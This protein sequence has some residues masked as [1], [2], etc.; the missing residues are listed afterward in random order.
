VDLDA[1]V[2][3]VRLVPGIG[4]WTAHYLALRLG[5]PDA[6]P[7]TDLGL[8]RAVA[9]IGGVPASPAALAAVAERWRPWRAQAAIQLWLR[10]SGNGA[11]RPPVRAVTRS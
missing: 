1:F 2:R 3:S 5:E 6:F 11:S 4:P 7:V 10:S 9:R 8:Q